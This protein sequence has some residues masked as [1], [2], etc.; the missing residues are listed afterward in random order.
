MMEGA[1]DQGFD[2]GASVTMIAVGSNLLGR[3]E[4]R[5]VAVGLAAALDDNRPGSRTIG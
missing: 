3:R 4:I 1:I 5:P 2:A